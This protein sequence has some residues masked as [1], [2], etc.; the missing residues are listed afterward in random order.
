MAK[1]KARSVGS[2]TELIRQVRGKEAAA[3][4]EK[5]LAES[6]IIRQL[7]MLRWTRGMTVKEVAKETGWTT[8]A[9]REFESAKDAD[10]SGEQ[11]ADYA[12]AIGARFAVFG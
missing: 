8:A 9:V 10:V 12:K 1:K 11:V 4:H 3:E 2:V 7:R 6:R 5:S